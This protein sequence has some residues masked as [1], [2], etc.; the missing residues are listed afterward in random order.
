MLSCYGMAQDGQGTLWIGATGLV[1]YDG[2]RF[3]WLA[4]TGEFPE[5]FLG[6]IGVITST[7]R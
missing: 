1:R 6:N 5:A 7:P 4:T 2:E 3:H